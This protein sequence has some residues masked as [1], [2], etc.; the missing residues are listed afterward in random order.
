MDFECVRDD[1]KKVSSMELQCNDSP[2]QCV[3]KKQSIHFNPVEI[4]ICNISAHLYLKN[5]AAVNEHVLG[6]KTQ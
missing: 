1:Y 5:I 3:N 2:R 4:L 6:E